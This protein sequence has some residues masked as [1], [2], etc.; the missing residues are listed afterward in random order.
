MAGTLT[1]TDLADEILKGL[2]NRTDFATSRIVRILNISQIRIARAARWEELEQL[3]ERNTDVTADSDQDRMIPIPANVRDVYSIVLL[4]GSFSRKL[5][6][7]QHRTVDRRLPMPHYYE[8]RRPHSYVL[9]RENFELFPVPDAVYAL[10]ARVIMWPTAFTGTS[11]QVSDL[12]QKDDMLIALALSWAFQSLK[13]IE[14]ANRWW[15]VYKGLL[16]DAIDEEVENPDIDILP[17]PGLK[18]TST[19]APY[20]S[21]P[22]VR[23][24][25][26]D[27]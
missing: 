21:D 17:N 8:R 3:L 11:G 27:E 14:E 16:S 25:L 9:W 5:T 24:V 18:D 23:Q 1:Y 19:G 15:A 26:P 10:R 13:M 7:I 20:Y 2:G 6:K 22:F 4:D 12:D